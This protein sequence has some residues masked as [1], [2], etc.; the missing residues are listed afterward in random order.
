M[1]GTEV[2]PRGH[3]KDN[4]DRASAGARLQVGMG[5]AIAHHGELL[6][7]VFEDEDGH[8]HRG[9]VSLPLA[10]RQSLVTF[11]PHDSGGIRTRPRGRGKA[12]RAAAL[13]LDHLGY[14]GAAG[15][16]TIESS[17]P[18]GHGYGS[19]TSDVVATMR[20][21]AAGVGATLRRSTF[22]R[23]AVAAEGASDAVAYEDQ[24]VLFA[25][26]EGYVIEHFGDAFPPLIVVGFS[27]GVSPINTLRLQPA[28]YDSEEIEL[29]R[30]LRGLTYRSIRQQDARMLGRV[31]TTSARISQRHLP[32]PRWDSMLQLAEAYGALGIQVAHSGTLFGILVD[33]E[34]PKAVGHATALAK[35]VEDLGFKRA[36]I[37]AVNAEGA[38]LP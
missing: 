10:S 32:K 29:F 19:S 22:C 12:A 18:I 25:Q 2:R 30:V 34:M 20:A 7:G 37:F 33:P 6:Q 17:I 3:T 26:R 28:R 27:D 38:A 1:A 11:W 13:A 14:S 21:V 23:L 4:A 35:A 16:L 31:A 8:L 15:D 36:Q 9:L 5:R 24:V